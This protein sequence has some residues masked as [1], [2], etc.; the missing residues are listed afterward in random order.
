MATENKPTD[1]PGKEMNFWDHADVLRGVL[2]KIA[3]AISACA[4]VLFSFMTDIFDNIILAP[5]RADF[6]LYRLFGKITSWSDL[7][8]DF[9]DN[10]F[11]VM[12]ININLASQF[13]IHISTSFWLAIVLSTPLTLYWLWTFIRPGLYANE[14]RS[15]KAA[16]FMGNLMFYM[17]VAVGYFVVFPLT[18]RFLAE[19]HVSEYIPNQISL[20]SYMDNFLG[21]IFVM[22][23]V[24][25]LP[26]LCWLLGHIGILTRK[27]FSTYRRHA[28][29][30]LM[31][32]AAFIT[33]TGDPFTLLVVFT[34]IY[35]LWEVS[36]LLVPNGK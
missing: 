16:F 23:L 24:F 7:L 22:G 25:E 6:P 8:P 21:I 20:D 13:F 26:L 19:Y 12:L 15:V 32:L 30:V 10:G 33:P 35:M 14:Q 11:A 17:G 34:P 4:I 18:L 2:I 29:V 5:C 36:A 9:T 31:I 28:I 1:L 27:F 3:I